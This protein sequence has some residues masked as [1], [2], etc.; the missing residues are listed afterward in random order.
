MTISIQ[1]HIQQI[2]SGLA[3]A[4]AS[5]AITGMRGSSPAYLLSRLSAAVERNLFVIAP[6]SDAAE[7]LCREL[8]FYMGKGDAAQLFPAWESAPF[9][10]ASPHPDVTGQRL[11]ALF[12]MMNG[13]AKVVV[14]PAAALCQRLLSRVDLGKVSDYLVAGEEADREGLLAKLV[15]LGY[16]HV[17]LVE[18]RGSFASRGGIVDI[19][20]PNL[21]APVRI[22]FFGDFVETI[23]SFAP[24]TQRSLQP[25]EELIL[26]PSREIVLN[27]EV[28][29]GLPARLKKLCDSQ[30]IPLPRR[31]ELLDQLQSAIYPPGIEYLQPIFHPELETIFDYAGSSS[32]RVL[33]DPEGIAAAVE[34][35]ISELELS[36]HRAQERDDIL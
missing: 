21:A 5:L 19:F 28:M 7:E 17:P 2:L 12:Q 31:R 8:R 35:F 24:L 3:P 14:A 11:N 10:H 27:E 33:I 23:R 13:T 6:D 15:R 36:E 25:L 22:E 4:D 18:D 32:I 16:S 30:D 9:E 26:L 20:P 29:Q 1:P 34:G